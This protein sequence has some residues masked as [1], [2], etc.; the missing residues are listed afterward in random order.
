MNEVKVFLIKP[1]WSLPAITLSVVVLSYCG[2][3]KGFF[4]DVFYFRYLF[5]GWRFVYDYTFGLL[6]FGTVYLLFFSLFFIFYFTFAKPIKDKKWKK[7][8]SNSINFFC[9]IYL[10]FYFLW[11]FNYQQKGL[12]T[13]LDLTE[14]QMTKEDLIAELNNIHKIALS[15]RN[16]IILTN[17]SIRESNIPLILENL[18]RTSQKEILRS[19]SLPNIGRVRVRKLL[20][21]GVLL[22]ISTAGVYIPFVSEGHIDKGLHPV[23]WPFTM[24]HE[25]AHGYGITDEGECNFVAFVTCINSSNA[26][27]RYSGLLGYYRYL[28]SNYR[29]YFREEYAAFYQTIDPAIIKDMVSINNE[30]EKYPDIL[31]DVR[32]KIYDSYLKSH[33]VKDGLHSYSTIIQL[34]QMWKEANF[35]QD[36]ITQISPGSG[37]E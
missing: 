2:F 13:K 20:P 30:L 4:A 32:D 28:L 31:P 34:V 5:Q 12:A 3:L 36:L 33:G 7:L 25:M 27:I 35:N 15:T 8:G 14:I 9:I 22:R 21:K 6:P 18:I 37:H 17:D 24:A 11:G 10:L 19:W 23:Q 26:I 29:L 1:S 16:K